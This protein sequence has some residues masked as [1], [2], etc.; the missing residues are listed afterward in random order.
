MR[1]TSASSA[2]PE[3]T[4]D[5]RI[6][7]SVAAGSAWRRPVSAAGL[8]DLDAD[9]GRRRRRAW[10]LRAVR[11][12]VGVATVGDDCRADRCRGSGRTPRTRCEQNEPLIRTSVHDE[13]AAGR[14]Q[15]GESRTRSAVALDGGDGRNRA[16]TIGAAVLAVDRAHASVLDRVGSTH[17]AS[18][19]CCGWASSPRRRS[20]LRPGRWAR[21]LRAV[22]YVGRR[23]ARRRGEPVHP[24]RCSV[25]SCSVSGCRSLG[26]RRAPPWCARRRSRLTVPPPDDVP[27]A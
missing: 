1:S 10:W 18:P 27:E 11:S 24:W 14:E 7:A 15:A 9:V 3:A 25:S 4:A 5:A 6:A 26:W 21:A 2:T 23:H 13:H 19:G 16:F 12:E 17:G 20:A 22:R 8:H